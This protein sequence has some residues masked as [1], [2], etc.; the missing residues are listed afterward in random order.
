MENEMESR[1]MKALPARVL[2]LGYRKI[3]SRT[4]S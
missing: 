2:D 1:L 3:I 4:H